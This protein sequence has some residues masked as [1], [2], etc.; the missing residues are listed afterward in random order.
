[1]VVDSTLE[2]QTGQKQPLAQQGRLHEDAPD[3]FGLHIGVVMRQ[4]GNSRIPVDC[5]MVR[6]RDPPRH[7]SEHRLF[8]WRLVRWRRPAWAARMVVS[9]AAA[10]AAK[11]NLQRMQR[12]GDFLVRALART[13]CCANGQALNDRVT[14]VPTKHDRRCGVP[15]DA[16]GRRRPYGTSTK[17]ACRRP[18]GDGTMILSQQRHNE[19]PQQTNILVTNLPAVSARQVVDG[20]RRR[21]L[22]ELLSKELTGATGLGQHHVSNDPHRV[23]R[24]IAISVMA[25]LRIVKFHEAIPERGAGSMLTLQ[26]KF[27]WQLAQAPLARSAEQRLRKALQERKAA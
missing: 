13:W 18:I 19:G 2:G 8:R 15:L 3:T 14:H 26:R 17:R 25:D 27:T 21:W 4:G 6:H 20:Y 11:A 23:E 16:P 9:A 7:Q 12:R 22:V 10:C 24:S 1:M 5:A